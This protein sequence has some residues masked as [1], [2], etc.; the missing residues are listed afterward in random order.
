[1]T[2]IAGIVILV[3]G[4]VCLR[5]SLNGKPRKQGM[6][7][8]P[9]HS[10][11]DAIQAK[12]RVQRTSCDFYEVKPGQEQTMPTSPWYVDMVHEGILFRDWVDQK[13]GAGTYDNIVR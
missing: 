13:Y 2:I 3:V 11:R 8:T 9:T 12:L 10:E 4:L 6:A 7:H 5:I 1:M